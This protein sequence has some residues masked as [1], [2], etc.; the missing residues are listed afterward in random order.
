M[1]KFKNSFLTGRSARRIAL[2]AL[3]GMSI[4]AVPALAAW[5]PSST[6]TSDRTAYDHATQVGTPSALH[7]FLL[8]YPDSPL[9]E[10][11]LEALVQH[12]TIPG[13]TSPGSTVQDP[14]CDLQSLITPAAG[15]G[16]GN[17]PFQDPPN[18]HSFRDRASGT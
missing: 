4:G 9:A 17:G 11:A 16:T 13:G 3:L 6:F 14:G 8:A 5:Q 10:K 2:F 7:N 1:D 18:E 12:C 15:P